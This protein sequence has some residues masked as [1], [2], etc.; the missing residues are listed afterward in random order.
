MVKQHALST[1]ITVDH[2]MLV[3]FLYGCKRQH[4]CI[5]EYRHCCCYEGMVLKLKCSPSRT[6]KQQYHILKNQPALSMVLKQR[7][8]RTV[9]SNKGT[10]EEESNNNIIWV[11]WVKHSKEHYNKLCPKLSLYLLTTLYLGNSTVRRNT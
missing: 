10:A 1:H 9:R 2:F 11:M 4:V 7:S 6:N 3:L 5:L 8:C